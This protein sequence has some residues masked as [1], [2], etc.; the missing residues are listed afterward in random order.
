MKNLTPIKEIIAAKGVKAKSAVI[1]K[2]KYDEELR[3]FLYYALNPLLSYNISSVTL[4]EA[5]STTVPG[6]VSSLRFSGI[7]ECCDYLSRLRGIDGA[8]VRQVKYLL[9]NLS[10][11]VEEK[12]LYKKLL[13]KSLRLGVTAKTVN[14]IIPDLIPEWE[15]QQA[16]PIEKYPIPSG[17]VFYLTEKLNGVRATFY[18]GNLIA[19]SGAVFEGLD[20]IV[21]E[22]EFF[23]DEGFVLDGE[24]RV[25]GYEELS[26]NEKFRI[27]AGILNSDA[28]EKTEIIYTIFDAVP[29]ADFE[30]AN[31]KTNY[32]ARRSILFA[33]DR[34]LSDA[35]FSRVLPVLYHG[36]DTAVIEKFLDRMTEEDKEGLIVNLDVPYKRTRHR[37]ILKV[38]RFYTMDLPIIGVEAGE[39][40][41]ENTLGALVLLYEGNEVRVGSGFTDEDRKYFWEHKDEII[42][43]ICEVKYKEI[44]QDKNTKMNSLQFPVF[45]GLRFDKTESSDC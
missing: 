25:S 20:H 29:T 15:V 41:L 36:N 26:D 31:P 43:G 23:S 2:Y 10:V 12:E 14:K 40:R 38:K 3:T 8:T 6:G 30:S 24:L 27:T 37:G 19:R 1:E 22:I 44:S 5:E 9:D 13:T 4:D 17:E 42:G 32:T 16:Y 35:R 18:K 45:V 11:G 28:P 34:A 21:K 7:F 33:I 39:G